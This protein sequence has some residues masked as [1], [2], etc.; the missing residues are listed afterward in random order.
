MHPSEVNLP[1]TVL[2]HSTCPSTRYA[3]V[4]LDVGCVKIHDVISRRGTTDYRRMGRA[5]E[6]DRRAQ[7]GSISSAQRFRVGI[8]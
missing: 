6:T 8:C 4:L 2:E 5:A 3:L 1:N 7:A